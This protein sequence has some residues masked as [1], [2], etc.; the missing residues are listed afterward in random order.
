MKIRCIAN[1]G[2]AL[3][4]YELKELGSTETG[5]FGA[6]AST[7][8]S[9]IAPGE[10]YLVMGMMLGDGTLWYLVD[11]HGNIGLYPSPLFE[12]LDNTI[13]SC[14][15]F[16]SLSLDLSDEGFPYQEALWGYHEFVFDKTHYQDVVLGGNEEAERI[17]FRRKI[18]L[19]NTLRSEEC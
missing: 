1:T 8:F 17:Y 7:V 18:E 6:T 5:R 3:K 9:G 14:W 19:E 11:D 2:E 15:F 16:L 10:E 4:P 13:P 12:I